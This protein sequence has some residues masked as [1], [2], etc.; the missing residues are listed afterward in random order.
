MQLVP[1]QELNIVSASHAKVQVQVEETK[2]WGWIA[3][4]AVLLV[5]V[6]VGAYKLFVH[7]KPVLTEKDTVVLADFANSTGDPSST[8]RLRQGLAVELEQS[9]FL[10]LISD[11][12]IQ[13]TLRLMGQPLDARLTPEIAHDLCQRTQSAAYLTG[14]IASLGSQYVLGL[15]A[16]SCPTGDV[17]AEE[18]ETA[19]GKER[20]LAALD[21]AASK[22][23]EKL[24]ESL[25]TVEKI[26]TPLEQATTPSLEA[27]QAY[28]LGRRTQLERDEFA[29]AVPFYQR[30]IKFDPS[31]A[32]AYAAL[33][34]VYWN[35][36][37]TL[38]G[39]ENARKAYELR[40]TSSEPERFY[41]ESTY[42]HYVTGDLEKARQSRYLDPHIPSKLLGT[43]CL[44][45]LY[46]QEG[47]YEAALPHIRE[48]I[49]LDP[50]KAAL[51]FRD[52]VE[53]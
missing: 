15:K 13:Q 28:M 51:G 36:G 7:R 6:A 48:A 1:E 25:K 52:L 53:T 19:A 4:A 12:H 16:V 29:A 38:Q 41:I 33:G 37:Q 39:E 20:V 45:Q 10:S 22:L 42:Y 8:A 47:Q 44:W 9:P 43:N 5:A 18:Q 49:Q 24:G 27:L 3:V 50:W 21:Q 35:S 46:D 23:R 30:A 17:L 11:Q 31:F 26:N 14:S 40:A 2:P 34:S 32:L